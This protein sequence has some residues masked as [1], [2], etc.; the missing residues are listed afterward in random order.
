MLRGQS[1]VALPL[2]TG[3]NC[4]KLWRL[5][6]VG[7]AIAIDNIDD[8]IPSIDDYRRIL[9]GSCGQVAGCNDRRP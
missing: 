7:I 9:I 2:R 4:L 8:G 1:P 5:H 3:S 6:P